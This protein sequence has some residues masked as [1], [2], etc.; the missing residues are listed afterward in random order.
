MQAPVTHISPLASFRRTRVLPALGRV[1]VRVG[2][3]VNATDVIAEGHLQGQHIYLDA[4]RALSVTRNDESSY[5]LGCKVGDFVQRGDIL[6]ETKGLLPRLLRA[7]EDGEIIS[8]SG[9]QILME[10]AQNTFQLL[11][12]YAG[13]VVESVPERGAV[14]DING[15]L[16]QAAWGN[17]K[18]NQGLL[19]NLARSP[20][21][22]LL[23]A[24]LDVS[25][26]GGVIFAGFCLQ[27]DTLQAVA[28]LTPRGLI[29][30]SMSTDLIPLASNLNFPVV[31]L[32]GY[33]RTPVNKAAY[34]IL[35]TN[36]KR[37]ICLN[38]VG[39][40]P[41]RG[42]RP[43]LVIPLSEPGEGLV[44]TDVFK[45]GQTVRIQA[46]PFAGQVGTLAQ[47]TPGVVTLS[48]GLRT[49]AAEVNLENNSTVIIPL[50]NLDVLE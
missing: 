33:G 35:T 46:P 49:L 36:D 16:I 22:E 24:R 4:L 17:G 6:A 3:K 41:F 21:E 8:T 37:D 25:L 18:I 38:A 12:G 42:E 5:S 40:D 50:S 31:L 39:R 34:T 7:P 30:G 11:A 14:I 26:R 45:V 2:Q 13:V 32:E 28:D 27:A 1:L 20:E 23:R 29:L 15:A 43:E 9:G 48:S 19:M 47:L 10:I 44:E